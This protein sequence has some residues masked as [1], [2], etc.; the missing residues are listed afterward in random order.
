M[1]IPRDAL[2]W[3][4]ARLPPADGNPEPRPPGKAIPE[5]PRT[6][7]P[8]GGG[9]VA[10]SAVPPVTVTCGIVT[11]SSASGVGR[12][13][14]SFLAVSLRAGKSTPAAARTC[15]ATGCKLEK[16]AGTLCP[17]S[18]GTRTG[19]S[20][21][22]SPD[23]PPDRSWA[24]TGLRPGMDPESGFSTG[25]SGAGACGNGGTKKAAGTDDDTAGVGGGAGASGAGG[26]EAEA[27]AA[28]G[29]GCGGRLG[30]GGGSGALSLMSAAD[31][32]RG[33]GS[34]GG[35]GSSASALAPLS[36]LDSGRSARASALAFSFSAR[37]AS[38]FFVFSSIMA[39]G[40]PSM[41][42]TTM[43]GFSRPGIA[44]GTSFIVF[45]Y[46]LSMW[47]RRP[48]TVSNLRPH[49]EQARC[50]VRWCWMSVLTVSNSRSQ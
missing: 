33:R 43:S 7:R 46:A 14:F 26:L 47:T 29:P 40:T 20:A 4:K 25:L 36:P 49:S 18:P 12:L 32:R 10:L 50:F 31:T 30:I 39:F 13:P 16:C 9:P 1:P 38:A 19:A 41:P 23:G 28:T 15:R 17:G 45:L 5:P 21:S 34:S 44:P 11:T 2:N 27:L 48:V 22:L 35:R 6:P 8:T 42:W 24:T 37:S 3:P